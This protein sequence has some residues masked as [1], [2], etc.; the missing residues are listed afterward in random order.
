MLLMADSP[1]QLSANNIVA[2]SFLAAIV[3]FLM[4]GV[5]WLAIIQSKVSILDVLSSQGFFRTVAVMGVIAATAVLGL[6][7]RLDSNIAGAILSGVGGFV[8]GH[9]SNRPD[10]GP[11][12]STSPSRDQGSAV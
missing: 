2:L 6:A 9:L 4:W 12:P 10:G 1:V 7:G 5:F 3:L 8:L 11:L